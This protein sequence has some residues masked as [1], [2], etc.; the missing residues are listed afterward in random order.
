MIFKA[1]KDFSGLTSGEKEVKAWI[2]ALFSKSFP[3]K[4]HKLLVPV[5][6]CPEDAL[7]TDFPSRGALLGLSEVEGDLGASATVWTVTSIENCFDFPAGSKSHAS[8]LLSVL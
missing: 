2:E 3:F 8:D 1:T 6:K 7:S 5:S 4:T